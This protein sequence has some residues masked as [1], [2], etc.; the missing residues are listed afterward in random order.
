MVTDYSGVQYDF[1]YMRKPI[2][3]F[4]P[5]ELP[6]HYDSSLDYEKD[7]FGP[8]IKKENELVKELCIKMDNNCAND[9]KYI[10]R[11]NNFF[12]YDDYNNCERII[13][14]VDEYL[15]ESEDEESIF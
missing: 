14:A 13:K 5:E 6:P 2:L 10:N 1:A 8:I 9:I 4:H 7:G 11:A 3:Y 12:E 15:G